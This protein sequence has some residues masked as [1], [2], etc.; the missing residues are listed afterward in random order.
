M[1]VRQISDDEIE[2]CLP[3]GIESP[4]A[5]PADYLWDERWSWLL[6]LGCES[7]GR[8]RRGPNK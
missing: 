3:D 2:A 6:D 5:G 1:R 8:K 4:K 7:Q